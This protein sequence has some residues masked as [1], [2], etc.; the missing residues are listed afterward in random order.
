VALLAQAGSEDLE[1]LYM[2]PPVFVEPK[3]S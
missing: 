1:P 3:F 2:H